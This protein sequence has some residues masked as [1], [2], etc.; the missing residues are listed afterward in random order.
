MKIGLLS[1]HMVLDPK[2]MGY[3]AAVTR[4]GMLVMREL[5]LLSP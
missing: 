1:M 3:F 5:M 2:V 4:Y